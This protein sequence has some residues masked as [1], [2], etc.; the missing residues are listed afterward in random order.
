M[1]SVTEHPIVT[2][3]FKVPNDRIEKQRELLG[4]TAAPAKLVPVATPIVGTWVN[5]NHETGGLVRVVIAPKVNAITVH[6]FGACHP[7]PCDWGIVDG[8]IYADSVA[9]TPAVAFTA[10]YKFAFVET[11]IVGHLYRGVLFVETFEH[12]IDNSGR[13]DYYALEMLSK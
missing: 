10:K 1:P 5:C 3:E 7:T 2:H 12:F 11:T 6:A 4:I 8:M 9:T 13:A